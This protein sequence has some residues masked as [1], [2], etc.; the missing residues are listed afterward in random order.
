MKMTSLPEAIALR[1]R[2]SY[3][4]F[5]HYNC[6]IGFEN[7]TSSS[8]NSPENGQREQ[9]SLILFIFG[10]SAATTRL[11]GM[12]QTSPLTM[13]IVPAVVVVHGEPGSRT[14]EQQDSS[15]RRKER[16]P[17]SARRMRFS[18]R[19]NSNFKWQQDTSVVG[20]L[21]VDS[22][23]VLNVR[24]KL[25]EKGLMLTK[26]D[27]DEFGVCLR[28]WE[29]LKL[30]R[31]FVEAC[32]GIPPAT[33]CC[34]LLKDQDQTIRELATL[35]NKGWANSINKKIKDRGF[36][37]S[38]F[39]WS[40]QNALGKAQTTVLLVRFHSLIST[41][42]RLSDISRNSTTASST[43]GAELLDRS[44]QEYHRKD[45]SHEA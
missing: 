25:G 30:R 7:G 29:E 3:Y 33:Q 17:E 44:R 40:W 39:A 37:I 41:T 28:M 42:R 1:Y 26:Q 8:S 24:G 11:D 14:K 6:H 34:G 31:G 9:L 16:M 2:T 5:L 32:E 22:D 38:C 15:T 13:C 4:Y 36:K 18:N 43:I 35:L 21:E 45:D 12:I 23:P 19:R 20:A 27:D 10:T